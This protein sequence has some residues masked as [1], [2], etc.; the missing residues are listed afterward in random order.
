ML[1]FPITGSADYQIT[2][3]FCSPI[4]RLPNYSITKSDPGYPPSRSHSSQ[5]G[6][7][8][9][10]NRCSAGTAP[11]CLLLRPVLAFDYPGG[12]DAPGS[13]FPVFVARIP[14]LCAPSC[15]LWLELLLLPLPSLIA[16][17]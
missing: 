16:D 4:S 11:G 3:S 10:R 17:C 13:G 12:A 1:A 14:C 9:T 7:G 5:F 15:P 2:R 6:V 8:F